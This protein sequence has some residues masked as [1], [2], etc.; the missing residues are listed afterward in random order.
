MPYNK[1]ANP[2][3]IASSELGW[4][5]FAD[6]GR[7][8]NPGAVQVKDNPYAKFAA[9]MVSDIAW[10]AGKE[11]TAPE[12]KGIDPLTGKDIY[13]QGIFGR[14]V[15][16]SPVL[17]E[18]SYYARD[19]QRVHDSYNKNMDA[20]VIA[21]AKARET[22][23]INAVDS[24]ASQPPT[25][26]TAPLVVDSRKSGWDQLQQKKNL[27]E[28]LRKGYYAQEESFPNWWELDYFQDEAKL[29]ANK[30]HNAAAK[31]LGGRGTIGS[32][33]SPARKHFMDEKNRG[34][35]KAYD[36]DAQGYFD[37]YIY[38]TLK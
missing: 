5:G 26:A 32:A 15:F 20:E 28:R 6:G 7:M 36:A 8:G 19:E 3:G 31:W 13:E 17:P 24:A 21:D 30:R 29:E 18:N 27:Q 22:A 12:Y 4:K 11:L 35:L 23:R 2:Y 1:Q 14:T 16:G 33:D 10:N 25:R 38:P 9:N 37:K 34:A